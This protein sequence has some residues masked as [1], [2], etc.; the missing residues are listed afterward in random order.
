[1]HGEAM[2]PEKEIDQAWA[3]LSYYKVSL[4]EPSLMMESILKTLPESLF[5]LLL[6]RGSWGYRDAAR[7]TRLIGSSR[8]DNGRVSVRFPDALS[9]TGCC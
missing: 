5:L 1:M 6:G 3:W 9:V 4:E 7:G 8:R 2:A